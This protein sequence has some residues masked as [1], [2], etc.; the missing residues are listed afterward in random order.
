MVFVLYGPKSIY[1]S[2]I[3]SCIG[4]DLE[5]N[6][7]VGETV[8]Q[9]QEF[10]NNENICRSGQYSF[11]SFYDDFSKN[12]V[13]GNGDER[14]LNFESWWVLS[15]MS[16]CVLRPRKIAIEASTLCQLNCADCYMRKTNFDG[17]GKGSLSVD[18]LKKFLDGADYVDEVE[19]SNNGEAFLAPDFIEILK[20]LYDRK[21]SVTLL[22]G[23]N[24]NSAQ[25]NEIEALV[26]YNVRE[27]S[28]S[29]DGASQEIYEL[30]RKNGN[31]NKVFENIER[32]NYYKKKYNSPFPILYWQYILMEHNECDI[33]Q[34][35][36][37][38][39]ELDMRIYF[40][41]NWGG[42][43]LR[44]VDR[45]RSET[46]LDKLVRDSSFRW[47]DR[48]R[49]LVFQPHINWDGRLL[50]CC[51]SHSFDFGMNVFDNG[52]EKTLNSKKYK[53][54]IDEVF[55]RKIEF[56]NDTPCSKCRIYREHIV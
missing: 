37:K 53:D 34:A 24:F 5:K 11:V 27:M 23:V 14:S 12:S 45:V 31:I 7:Y 3:S 28:V 1:K 6:I 54:N 26:K 49:E 9:L 29:I 56:K 33:A 13:L 2:V 42:N 35:K 4:I 41:L 19:L 48:C 30:Y 10:M 44:D 15:G 20:C 21:I 46:G 32:V 22:N 39:Q 55:G 18:R 25:D 38:S 36:K 51:S 8:E 47:G 40:K 43:R 52:L 50:G 16:G 17:V